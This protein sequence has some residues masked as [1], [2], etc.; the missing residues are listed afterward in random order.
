[1]HVKMTEPRAMEYLDSMGGPDHG[2]FD[3]MERWVA[4]EIKDKGGEEVN[5][6]WSRG[7]PKI[8]PQLNGHDCGVFMLAYM[9][10]LRDGDCMLAA[11]CSFDFDQ[12]DIQEKRKK[13]K[14]TIMQHGVDARDVETEPGPVSEPVRSRRRR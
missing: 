9:E 6:P 12:S 1:M 11:E 2:A 7:R 8:P 4:D 3:N 10:A 13:A 5:T 14:S